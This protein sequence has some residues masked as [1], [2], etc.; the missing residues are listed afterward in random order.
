MRDATRVATIPEM[1]PT[2]VSRPDHIRRLI[3]GLSFIGKGF[4][5]ITWRTQKRATFALTL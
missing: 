3:N 2:P 4:K 5:Q 1:A